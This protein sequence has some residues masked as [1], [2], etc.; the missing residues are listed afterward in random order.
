MLLML[1]LY[2]LYPAVIPAS[3]LQA[4]AAAFGA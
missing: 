2:L 4:A 3:F 1:L